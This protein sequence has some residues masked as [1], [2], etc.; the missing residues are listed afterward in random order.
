[1]ALWVQ[2]DLCVQSDNE[3]SETRSQWLRTSALQRVPLQ[4]LFER[5]KFA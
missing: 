4:F 1:M 5:L 3:K 2:S